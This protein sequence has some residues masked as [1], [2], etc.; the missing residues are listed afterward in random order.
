VL[1]VAAVVMWVLTGR[2]FDEAQRSDAE[3]PTLGVLAMVQF[4]FVV[5]VG[6]VAVAQAL[7]YS[8]RVVGPAY[9][10][11]TSLRRLREGETKFQIELRKG[12][13]LN[14]I[15]DELNALLESFSK[16]DERTP[17]ESDRSLVATG[18]RG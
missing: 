13:E 2:L 12:D 1:L 3:L 10:I 14:S 18:H 15:A 16:A 11:A 8:N 17:D 9:R 6:V 5:G 4:L 7:R